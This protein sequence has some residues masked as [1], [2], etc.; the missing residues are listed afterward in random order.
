[1]RRGFGAQLLLD[2]SGRMFGFCTGADA[3]AEHECGSRPMQEK[4][5]SGAQRYQR[6]EADLVAK[7]R[8]QLTAP[9]G[10]LARLLPE[11]EV[12]YPQLLERKRIDQNLNQ[13][14]FLEGV[15]DGEPAAV[16]GFSPN[17]SLM[18]FGL[19]HQELR[20]YGDDLFVTGAW[21]DRSFAIAVRGASRV[22]LLAEFA[23]AIRAGDGLFAGTFIE[24][25]EKTHLSGVLVVRESMLRPQDNAGITKA[26][27]EFEAHLRLQARSR[28]HELQA[29]RKSRE[30]S[31][32]RASNWPGHIWPLWRDSIVDGEVVY[33]LN[34]AYGIKAPYY[35][36]YDY[37][38]LAAW[39]GAEGKKPT[40]VPIERKAA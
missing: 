8:R 3:C 18:H 4:L 19:Q 34:P 31:G 14:V 17:G 2:E 27:A 16:F 1:M 5:S 33:G 37:D 15:V 32:S 40:L 28:V 11:K 38:Q 10:L 22:H 24:D 7:L 20:F 29:L 39:I 13:L 9:K 26:Q 36:P 25:F 12:A 6:E 23:D 21:S 30:A 35:G